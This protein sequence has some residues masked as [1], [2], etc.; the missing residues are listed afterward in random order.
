MKLKLLNHI[1]IIDLDDH[2]QELIEISCTHAEHAEWLK[3]INPKR[4]E[5][6]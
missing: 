1:E 6:K 3:R 5:S 4:G 2:D